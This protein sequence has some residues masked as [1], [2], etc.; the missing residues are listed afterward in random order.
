M[1]RDDF[2]HV[3]F[4][5]AD[6]QLS[7]TQPGSLVRQYTAL[8]DLRNRPFTCFSISLNISKA[9]KLTLSFLQLLLSLAAVGQGLFLLLLALL[10]WTP[11]RLALFRSLFSIFRGVFWIHYLRARPETSEGH[12][13]APSSKDLPLPTGNLS[14]SEPITQ[15]LIQLESLLTQPSPPRGWGQLCSPFLSENLTPANWDE[16]Y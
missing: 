1:T 3:T 12:C 10:Y 2:G 14:P 4:C 8:K 9:Q 13:S 11:L 5:A 7:P 6:T 15:V 16:D